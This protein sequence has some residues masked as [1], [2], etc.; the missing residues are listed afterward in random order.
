[1]VYHMSTRTTSR[2]ELYDGV[3]VTRS[4]FWKRLWQ[5]MRIKQRTNLRPTVADEFGNLVYNTSTRSRNLFTIAQ[6]ENG[7]VVYSVDP[8]DNNQ[9]QKMRFVAT[10]KEIPDALA[11]MVVQLRLDV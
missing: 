10:L 9:Q 4:S 8:H 5:K 3:P 6:I 2:D 1:M 11:V 7:F